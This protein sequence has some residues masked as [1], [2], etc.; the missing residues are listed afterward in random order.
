MTLWRND[1]FEKINL[2]IG[3]P[4]KIDGGC[5]KPWRTLGYQNLYSEEFS[6]DCTQNGC[7]QEHGENFLKLETAADFEKF[8][9]TGETLNITNSD[10]HDYNKAITTQGLTTVPVTTCTTNTCFGVF[11]F[12]FAWKVDDCT[13]F[14]LEWKQ[15]WNPLRPYTGFK[16]TLFLQS[17]F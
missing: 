3:I 17:M 11:Y 1:A 12:Q 10:E 6:N 14:V 15:N 7:D 4:L 13:V 2:I 16:N 5:R 8:K 9:V